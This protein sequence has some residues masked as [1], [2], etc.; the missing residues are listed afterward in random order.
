LNRPKTN[1]EIKV[2]LKNLVTK[3]PG[4]DDFLAEFYQTFKELLPIFLKVF[5]NW[6]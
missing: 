1:K 5:Q 4:P 3:T 2:I 6:N